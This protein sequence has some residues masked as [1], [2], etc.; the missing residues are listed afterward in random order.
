MITEKYINGFATV[1]RKYKGNCGKM[2][3]EFNL[4]KP[5]EDDVSLCSTCQEVLKHNRNLE[6]SLCNKLSVD[7]KKVMFAFTKRWMLKEL[8]QL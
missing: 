3:H 1:I 8:Q 6:K 2:S 5:W 7:R 4:L